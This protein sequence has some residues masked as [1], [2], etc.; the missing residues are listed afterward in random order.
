M[1]LTPKQVLSK[2]NSKSTLVSIAERRGIN[3]TKQQQKRVADILAEDVLKT[4]INKVLHVLKKK[5]LVALSKDG[6]V[7][8][9]E[10]RKNRG[11]HK[12]DGE[13]D[14]FPQKQTMIERLTDAISS[15]GVSQFFEQL[16]VPVLL[17]CCKSIDDLSD[18]SDEELLDTYG[19]DDLV[20]GIL[21][22][23]YTF[24]LQNLFTSFTVT[25]LATFA[26]DCDLSVKSQ[27]KEVLV[28]CIVEQK[29][30]RKKT[31]KRKVET[32]SKKKP[33]LKDGI[34]KV[35]LEQ[36]YLRSELEDFCR[37]K[38]M[39]ISGN[40]RDLIKRILLWFEGDRGHLVMPG[41]KRSRSRSRSK[42]R[43]EEESDE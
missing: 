28:D 21:Q 5:E 35:D 7:D 24:G 36:W 22:N 23:I 38:G 13:E 10:E 42:S 32:K 33:D 41:K 26:E 4:G 29:D 14:W 8:Y 1:S 37:E 9:E 40:K 34:K 43:K 15:F 17:E 31:V 6:N 16:P 11:P 19:Q 30:Y 20:N 3:L 12:E 18:F 27:A 39:K 25:E 2:F